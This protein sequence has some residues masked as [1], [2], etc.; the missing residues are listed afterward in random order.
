MTA[1]FAEF[2][3]LDILSDKQRN[4][5]NYEGYKVYKHYFENMIKKYY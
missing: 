5:D 3:L 1:K 2:Y 4:Y